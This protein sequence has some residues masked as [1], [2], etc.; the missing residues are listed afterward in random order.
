[1]WAW[2]TGWDSILV[3]GKAS[4][5]KLIEFDTYERQNFQMFQD[6]GFL[7]LCLYSLTFRVSRSRDLLLTNTIYIVRVRRTHS[8][9]HLTI[10]TRPR[11]WQWK[12]REA[13]GSEKNLRSKINR[14]MWWLKDDAMG[15][16]HMED[17]LFCFLFLGI[18]YWKVVVLEARG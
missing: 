10:Y 5:R 8:H 3:L 15:D 11:G 18:E 14:T 9:G 7:V 16:R 4:L 2:R 17:K 6:C 12:R 1:M 13:N